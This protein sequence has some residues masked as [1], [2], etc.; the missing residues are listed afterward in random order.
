MNKFLEIAWNEL[1]YLE[2]SKAAYKANPNVIYEKEAG[3]GADNYTKF[4]DVEKSMQGNQ[5]CNAFVNWCAVQRWGVDQAKEVL[6]TPGA[7]SFYT[8]TSS[9]YFKKANRWTTT[10]QKGAIIYFKNSQRIHHVGIVTD[11]S[12]NIVTTVEGNTSSDSYNNDGGCVASHRYQITDSKIAGYGLPKYPECAQDGWVL[13]GS[14]W[15]YYRDGKALTKEWVHYKHHWYRMGNDGKMLVGWHN[16]YDKD[17]KLCRCYF[18]ET[19]EFLGAEWHERS[20][21]VGYLEVWTTND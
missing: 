19:D 3:R 11:V 16:I 13:K 12:N 21:G 1:G 17:G 14:D 6:C 20:D 7:W 18:D 4:W 9:S 10:P 2:K 8:P 5:W 15:Y